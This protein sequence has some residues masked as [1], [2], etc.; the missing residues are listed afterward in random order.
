MRH[1][2][3]RLTS[4]AKVCLLLSPPTLLYVTLLL[5]LTAHYGGHHYAEVFSNPQCANKLQAPVQT[6]HGWGDKFGD[7]SVLLQ[8]SDLHI[9]DRDNGKAKRNLDDFLKVELQAWKSLADAVIVTGDL[10]NA[11]APQSFWRKRLLGSKSQQHESEWAYLAGV[12]NRVNESFAWLPVLGNHDLFGG[13]SPYLCK[14]GGLAASLHSCQ[15]GRQ[16]R[17]NHVTRVYRHRVPSDSSTETSAV[18]I[19]AIDATPQKPI[20]RPLNFFG[21]L[22]PIVDSLERALQEVEKEDGSDST[23]ILVCH[24]TPSTMSGGYLLESLANRN[25]KGRSKARFSALLN[26]HLHNLY[27]L[28][29]NGLQAVSRSGY[30]QLELPSMMANRR[31][32][33]LLIDHGVLSFHDRD[34]RKGI[35]ATEHL[36]I[37]V[38]NPPRAD[39]CAPGAGAAALLSTHIRFLVVGGQPGNRPI[40]VHVDNKYLGTATRGSHCS[41][42]A[43]DSASRGKCEVLFSVPWNPE[44]YN[45]NQHHSLK[46]EVDGKHLVEH[47]FS[48]SDGQ[49]PDTNVLA[50]RLWS[51][52]LSLTRFEW[53]SRILVTMGILISMF[54]SFLTVLVARSRKYRIAGAALCIYGLVLAFGPVIVSYGLSDSGSKAIDLVALRWMRISGE[55]SASTSVDAYNAIMQSLLW[56]SFVP[57]SYLCVISADNRSRS[58]LRSSFVA[59]I[60]RFAIVISALRGV[61]EAAGAHGLFACLASPPSL[62]FATLVTLSLH[63]IYVSPLSNYELMKKNV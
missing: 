57:L 28:A 33:V 12:A 15:N 16:H 25:G 49:R 30:L 7:I 59:Q 32:R 60:F 38:S 22:M 23:V 35:S 31:F 24:Y 13:V 5:G 37:F 20:H 2:G 21:E 4:E 6:L 34:V 36:Q 42:L 54:L 53:V 8:I 50:S 61:S 39:I 43:R 58:M 3:S 40:S 18:N 10:V 44:M 14:Y 47:I 52:I 29:P 9:N 45:D 19:I 63:I 41:Q 27:G 11:K 48:L 62:L 51:S 1:I 55:Y 46:I 26:G 17:S 56:T